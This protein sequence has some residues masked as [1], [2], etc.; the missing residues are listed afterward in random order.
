MFLHHSWRTTVESNAGWRKR[1]KKAA[2]NRRIIKYTLG[3]RTGEI[4]V[5]LA[6]CCTSKSLHNDDKSE[7]EYLFT[8]MWHFIII[9]LIPDY[10]KSSSHI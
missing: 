9:M 7:S 6:T 2:N 8:D 10:N 5:A 1:H 3:I 4:F